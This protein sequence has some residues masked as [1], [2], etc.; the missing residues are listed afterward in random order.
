MER[1]PAIAVGVALR[2][3]GGRGRVGS[4]GRDRSFTEGLCFHLALQQPG[5]G[6]QNGLAS[7]EAPPPLVQSA[8]AAMFLDCRPSAAAE[9]AHIMAINV[10]LATFLLPN[11]RWLGCIDA[12]WSFLD[13]KPHLVYLAC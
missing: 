2:G 12:V 5:P 11:S 9:H 10:L 1:S 6:R 4:R 3:G 7:M 8:V 13:G